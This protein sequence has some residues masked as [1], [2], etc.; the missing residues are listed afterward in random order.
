VE[1]EALEVLQVLD[2]PGPVEAEA[3]VDGGQQLRCGLAPGTQGGGIRGRQ[4]VEDHEGQ[5]ADHEEQHDHPEQ[6][7]DD[8]GDH[9][10]KRSGAD[11]L[12]A[13]PRRA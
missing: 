1:D 6:P 5:E 3:V 8:E 10:L 7:A 13:V 11:V 12:R 2:V 4:R 9:G